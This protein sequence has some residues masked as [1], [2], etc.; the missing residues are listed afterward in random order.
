MN[1]IKKL[2]MVFG[3]ISVPILLFVFIPAAP[4]GFYA[5]KDFGCLCNVGLLEVQGDKVYSFNRAHAVGGEVGR[6]IHKDGYYYFLY[7]DGREGKILYSTRAYLKF[8]MDYGDELPHV[9]YAGRAYL[10][11]E[12]KKVVRAFPREILQESEVMDEGPNKAV[13]QTE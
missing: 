12:E 10:F 13:E 5:S 3:V 8:E 9:A 6:I 2:V 4:S 11:E 7:S 1:V